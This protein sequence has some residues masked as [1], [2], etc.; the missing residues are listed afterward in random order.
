MCSHCKYFKSLLAPLFCSKPSKLLSYF[1]HPCKI[2]SLMKYI[3]FSV[4]SGADI[5][6]Y[7]VVV[8]YFFMYTWCVCEILKLSSW[9][10]TLD[11]VYKMSACLVDIIELSGGEPRFDSRF[12]VPTWWCISTSQ[13][14]VVYSSEVQIRSLLAVVWMA[15]FTLWGCEEPGWTGSAAAA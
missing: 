14:G 12:S 11:H 6:V 15:R 2:N 4:W 9:N 7:I 1:H 3:A 5:I 8:C 10:Q 13:T